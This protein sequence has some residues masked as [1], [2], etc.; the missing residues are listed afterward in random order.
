MEDLSTSESRRADFEARQSRHS[1]VVEPLYYG[2]LFQAA[3]IPL[4]ESRPGSPSSSDLDL[5]DATT[6]QVEPRDEVETTPVSSPVRTPSTTA[7]PLRFRRPPHSPSTSKD[8][9]HPS[10]TISDS[11]QPTP[12]TAK[13]R[14]VST[15]FKRSHDIRPLYLVE[16]NTKLPEPDA[17]LPSL[18]SSH[19][20]SRAPS[21]QDS[22]EE[23]YASALES[24]N[25]SVVGSEHE[26]FADFRIPQ[27][28]EGCENYLNSGQTTPRA[29]TFSPK[30]TSPEN[31]HYDRARRDSPTETHIALL[32]A[33]QTQ[34]R[35]ASSG[36]DNFARAPASTLGA[37]TQGTALSAAAPDD[38]SS[39]P[40]DA[41]RNAFDGPNI[42]DLSHA[43][44]SEQ[45]FENPPRSDCDSKDAEAA[46]VK[47]E[48][49]AVHSQFNE[50]EPFA[51]RSNIQKEKNKNK[52]KNKTKTQKRSKAS[53]DDVEP[54]ST[55]PSDLVIE[56]QTAFAKIDE[57]PRTAVRFDEPSISRQLDP[58]TLDDSNAL[59][60]QDWAVFNQSLPNESTAT[61]PT[62]TQN[63]PGRE[64]E[65]FNKPMPEP[66]IAFA[67]N[68]SPPEA[69][70][71]LEDQPQAISDVSLK[72]GSRHS[73]DPKVSEI[74]NLQQDILPTLTG[75]PEDNEDNP[76]PELSEIEK[77][78]E[79][80]LNAPN[81]VREN[82]GDLGP[83]TSKIEQLEEGTLP[84]S[85]AFCE[86]NEDDLVVKGA[87]I[88]DQTGH[89][90]D[91]SKPR[92]RSKAEPEVTILPPGARSDFTRVITDDAALTSATFDVDEGHSMDTLEVDRH[93][94]PSQTL[95]V[96]AQMPAVDTSSTQEFGEDDSSRS[97]APAS[98]KK[99]EPVRELHLAEEITAKEQE[100]IQHVETEPEAESSWISSWLPG[101]K[102]K[103]GKKVKGKKQTEPLE[104][105]AGP[106]D[107]P[108]QLTDILSQDEEPS[109]DASISAIVQNEPTRNV[110]T[111][112]SESKDAIN[113]TE[114]QKPPSEKLGEVDDWDAPIKKSKAKKGKKRKSDRTDTPTVGQASDDFG[115]NC[116]ANDVPIVA[117]DLSFSNASTTA[118]PQGS[119]QGMSPATTEAESVS[120]FKRTL[121]PS[122]SDVKEFPED[123]EALHSSPQVVA[124]EADSSPKDQP[125]VE[126]LTDPKETLRNASPRE[127]SEQ[128]VYAE[129][130]QPREFVETLG[131]LES[132]YM[133][134]RQSSTPLESQI[135]PNKNAEP[136]DSETLS[137][138]ENPGIV[139]ENDVGKFD[140]L[141]D[142]PRPAYPDP[143]H[144]V[145]TSQGPATEIVPDEEWNLKS[146]SK[147]K[148]GKKGKQHQGLDAVTQLEDMTQIQD[149]Q[150][151]SDP[152]QPEGYSAPSVETPLEPV[153]DTNAD[154]EWNLTRSSKNRKGKNKKQQQALDDSV[155][156]EDLPQ[157]W[158]PGMPSDTPQP[159]VVT[160]DSIETSVE[161]TIE[162]KIE[163]EWYTTGNS[164]KKKG[165]NKTQNQ[166]I[167]IMP[168]PDVATATGA[169]P[170]VDPANEFQADDAWSM[171]A[172]SRNKK[173]GKK[174]DQTQPTS[175]L[176]EA[177][178][179][180]TT[181]TTTTPTP[182]VELLTELAD[183]NQRDDEWNTTGSS[184]K[185]K[186]K[187]GKHHQ[188]TDIAFQPEEPSPVTLESPL[189][190]TKETNPDSQW[191]TAHSST[192][193]NVA[194]NQAQ[195]ADI[196]FKSH[197]ASRVKET[198]EEAPIETNPD[199]EWNDT[200]SSIKKKKKGKKQAFAVLAQS[201]KASQVQD[202]SVD[203]AE[204]PEQSLETTSS[205]QMAPTSSSKTKKNRKKN[206]V[207]WSGFVEESPLEQTSLSIDA[208]YPHAKLDFEEQ[209]QAR[210]SQNH[211]IEE[212]K[213]DQVPVDSH[214]SFAD[215]LESLDW[216]NPTSSIGHAGT[217]TTEADVNDSGVV[218]LP[219]AFETTSQAPWETSV[220]GQAAADDIDSSGPSL[221]ID[222][223]AN[224][225]VDD[226]PRLPKE[227][228]PETDET[229][230]DVAPNEPIEPPVAKSSKQARKQAKKKK[231]QKWE[232]SADANEEQSSL[233]NPAISTNFQGPLD[234]TK[235]K[236]VDRPSP[237]ELSGTSNI[238]G[239]RSSDFNDPTE[240]SND[241]S[242]P[243]TTQ[244]PIPTA[245]FEEGGSDVKGMEPSSPSR[246]E[247]A[248]VTGQ[249]VEGQA[250]DTGLYVAAEEI[251]KDEGAAF[252]V[253]ATD[254]N[255]QIE[256][257][258]TTEPKKQ[259]KVSKK[260]K[261]KAKKFQQF[262]VNEDES[263]L[264]AQPTQEGGIQATGKPT[265]PSKS[266]EPDFST[267]DGY[268]PNDAENSEALET[269]LRRVTSN[270]IVQALDQ[271][272]Q[273]SNDRSDI[274]VPGGLVDTGD[275]R[276][277]GIRDLKATE[278]SQ[279]PNGGS[280][281]DNV[282]TNLKI[283][284]FESSV[285]AGLQ[286]AGFSPKTAPESLD[287]PPAVDRFV[288]EPELQPKPFTF[289][290]KKNKKKAKK[291]EKSAL[292]SQD[293][294]TRETEPSPERAEPGLITNQQPA[295]LQASE[296]SPIDHSNTDAPEIVPLT[297]AK[298]DDFDE[299]VAAGLEGA[300]FAAALGRGTD[301][302]AAEVSSRDLESGYGQVGT[303]CQEQATRSEPG[304]RRTPSP[305]QLWQ[306]GGSPIQ[307]ESKDLNH[308]TMAHDEETSNRSFDS[309]DPASKEAGEDWPMFSSKKNKRGTKKV[310]ASMMD[311]EYSLQDKSNENT[312]S[313]A[314]AAEL[315]HQPNQTD[316]F[317]PS[318]KTK[319]KKGKKAR[320]LEIE[321]ELSSQDT[322]NA[323]AQGGMPPADVSTQPDEFEPLKASR[324][325]K[326]RKKGRAN[327]IDDETNWG[328]TLNEEILPDSPPAG[329]SMQSNE[330]DASEPSSKKTKGKRTRKSEPDDRSS[331]KDASHEKTNADPISAEG[332]TQA[333]EFAFFEPS[334]KK[335]KKKNR[336]KQLEEDNF[337]SFRQDGPVPGPE[338]Q[339]TTQ[340][341]D[342]SDPSYDEQ[343][344]AMENY[345]AEAP[346]EDPIA[347]SVQHSDRD[348]HSHADREDHSEGQD[349]YK[350]D[351]NHADETERQHVHAPQS[352][353][354]K[355]SMGDGYPP[356]PVESTSRN[357]ASYLFSSPPTGFET[358]ETDQ[359]EPHDVDLPGTVQA[360]QV[361]NLTSDSLATDTSHDDRRYRERNPTPLYHELGAIAETS[362]E[363]SP[364]GRSYPTP[365]P[366]EWDVEKGAPFEK[367]AH[368]GDFS[369]HALET[370]RNVS[371]DHDA[372]AARNS[373]RRESLSPTPKGRAESIHQ[374]KR[375][376]GSGISSS[377][378][379]EVANTKR[380]YSRQGIKDDSDPLRSLSP[381]SN[382]SG[383]AVS[384][385]SGTPTLRRI[386]SVPSERSAS[387]DL[388]AANKRDADLTPHA[389][390]EE[391]R[392]TI[393]TTSSLDRPHNYQPLRGLGEVRRSDMAEAGVLVSY[394]QRSTIVIAAVN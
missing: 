326:K 103:K 321:P 46:K 238:Q 133:K 88:Q 281:G 274:N 5:P 154:D 283:D 94:D 334:S 119:K 336:R 202:Q 149:R 309:E 221:A 83:G 159:E 101:K 272:P 109:V 257:L 79:G 290:S 145:E 163:D 323:K 314:L 312:H 23:A 375:R 316:A 227:T 229:H 206:K 197:E 311:D 24:P 140:T 307:N 37:A 72:H 318:S 141:L 225:K 186:G 131:D 69:Y 60:G 345:N 167:D 31:T 319:K 113:T 147:K 260:E 117:Q 355:Q 390:A 52:N 14:P 126:E 188:P 200:S 122:H 232:P 158:D 368:G 310:H 209:T 298:D 35:P 240:P 303:Q 30:T 80:I 329:V 180:T 366:S 305:S 56:D 273:D 322:S 385:R 388:R 373:R 374:P 222:N 160:S 148:K 108:D 130:A 289:T 4:P 389:K 243:E 341:I 340:A 297:S 247:N 76:D 49:R 217:S 230:E 48:N 17:S 100:S 44:S 287:L 152:Q 184:K 394:D 86:E 127:T 177:E 47:H 173:K 3:S 250:A 204:P 71:Q 187:K 192:I 233:Q 146:G 296:E 351:V 276:H 275:D 365:D 301:S 170:S 25:P 115:S 269:D 378:E 208:N 21:V 224:S 294:A 387:S 256:G 226:A 252:S 36:S 295:K 118:N 344:R 183:A 176:N 18:P 362:R 135:L 370:D 178:S 333:N 120:D 380:V 251:E 143:S 193:E 267:Q 19:T 234:S 151:L 65:S 92:R 95:D 82:N 367:D 58:E 112:I 241:T 332:S 317:E 383:S 91:V 369:S 138:Q 12:G 128:D 245:E 262:E 212:L 84:A 99:D 169:E 190:S 32:N 288:D 346:P 203:A 22:S 174:S 171:T 331:F 68:E 358:I 74:E 191:N 382:R 106:Q 371:E 372:F 335:K 300:G 361:P 11:Q 75:V 63:E 278:Q 26:L 123:V 254:L 15:E 39:F 306:S 57:A 284:D 391:G 78:E 349:C 50:Q 89:V 61:V 377:T 1:S 261:R 213:D 110:T 271:N 304:N 279:S 354:S 325:N 42:G 246:I 219:E 352:D 381:L 239:N 66:D 181:T 194:S 348:S 87:D 210:D 13:A 201:E 308:Q 268:G 2:A 386:D 124:V 363:H 162:S 81:P 51:S 220:E 338:E 111:N 53:T 16:R 207:A 73:F 161:P 337:E 216:K 214:T 223:V 20:T 205:V 7:I 27:E 253:L 172:N 97:L 357:R 59:K 280:I 77:L 199:D 98:V 189:E 196:V 324:K 244:K 264:Q 38:S 10:P 339:M 157:D 139:R 360:R 228:Q 93:R 165:K 96:E 6:V 70:T 41:G 136:E 29:G 249:V 270:E 255:A 231:K 155:Q 218:K 45:D 168:E 392:S 242:N 114:S 175:I 33:I 85:I 132:G 393:S 263:E 121:P 359:A 347:R 292:E 8:Y 236:E 285:L 342:A 142:N 156:S 43:T 215:K 384:Q 379:S 237:H 302:H 144:P 105:P 293:H 291:R 259:S 40:S 235:E 107:G 350:K 179:A 125:S 9:S 28:Q 182:T 34:S 353:M 116:I 195:P 330:F 55:M 266:V 258:T 282:E 185:K 102:N 137:Y 150:T 364:S 211:N 64:E 166:P 134:A 327:G 277:V 198:S 265:S 67:S 164:K 62:P 153:K 54:M 248:T 343:A 286:N 299:I 90:E 104:L 313:D 320:A 315:P 356:S 376:K 328:E 129:G